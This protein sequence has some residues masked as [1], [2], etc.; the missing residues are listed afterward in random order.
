LI[1]QGSQNYHIDY[2]ELDPSVNSNIYTPVKQEQ[3]PFVEMDRLSQTF[4]VSQI[5]QTD[6]QTVR[7]QDFRYRDI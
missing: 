6:E 1:S 3:Y 7:K 2:K 4:G 5:R